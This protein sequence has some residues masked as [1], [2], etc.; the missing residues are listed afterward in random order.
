MHTFVILAHKESPYLE[1]CILSLKNQSVKS[2]IIMTTS[3][4]SKFLDSFSHKYNIKLLLNT[5]S[6]NIASDWTFAYKSAK[7]EYVTL[8]HQDDIY[9]PRYTKDCLSAIQ[10]EKN[11]DDAIIFT[12][13]QELF[14]NKIRS[15]NF[16]LFIKHLLLLPFLFQRNIHSTVLKRIILSLGTPIPCSSVM[17]HKA[18]IGP[19]SFSQIFQ[20]NMDWDAWLR[21]SEIRG[22]FIYIKKRLVIHRIHSDSQTSLQIKNKIRKKEDALIFERL[23]PRL[24]SRI[25]TSI[26]SFSLK[27]NK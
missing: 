21:L 6:P 23:W 24:L 10:I 19:F 18:Y 8:A 3:T 16:N 7:T 17:Y 15:Y 1:E 2:D 27:S 14:R 9:L 22:S 20:C 11:N 26:Y 4:P 5:Q 25:L 13:Y 12:N